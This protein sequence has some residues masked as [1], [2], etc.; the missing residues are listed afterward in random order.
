MGDS[1]LR[2][3]RVATATELEKGF[4]LLLPSKLG[5]AQLIFQGV[6][7][8]ELKAIL[9]AVLDLAF[10]AA[11]KEAARAFKWTELC[12]ILLTLVV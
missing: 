6:A 8:A 7:E 9:H 4:G 1:R 10:A 3:L 12:F 11:P 5:A 2:D